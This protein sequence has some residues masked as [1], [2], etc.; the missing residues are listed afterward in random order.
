MSA[1]TKPRKASAKP[2]RQPDPLE[3]LRAQAAA[4]AQICAQEE[5]RD[6]VYDELTI[7]GVEVDDLGMVML[8][9]RGYRSSARYVVRVSEGAPCLATAREHVARIEAALAWDWRRS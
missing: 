4:Q 8:V 9:C 2:R 7:E 6:R 1:A 3:P 5:R